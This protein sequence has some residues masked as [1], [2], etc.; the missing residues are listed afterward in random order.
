VVVA[1]AELV[2]VADDGQRP[3]GRRQYRA[4]TFAA[5]PA[6][7]SDDDEAGNHEDDVVEKQLVR[8]QLNG[9]HESTL[10]SEFRNQGLRSIQMKRITW[11]YML[12][13][14]EVIAEPETRGEACMSSICCWL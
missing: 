14:I 5:G 9:S 8:V 3:R 12:T 2:E 1:P 13:I 10:R 4:T 6:E 7:A 11:K